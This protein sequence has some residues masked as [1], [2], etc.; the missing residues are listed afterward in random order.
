MSKEN[1]KEVVSEALKA[2]E[3]LRSMWYI[4]DTDGKLWE[5]DEF[6]FSGHD[7]LR[8]FSGYEYEKDRSVNAV[9][10]QLRA[11]GQKAGQ[12][13]EVCEYGV[14]PDDHGDRCQRVGQRVA[15]IGFAIDH[16]V[17][18]DADDGG[19]QEDVLGH[20]NDGLVLHEQ[21]EQAEYRQTQKINRPLPTDRTEDLFPERFMIGRLGMNAQVLLVIGK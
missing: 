5:F 4:L 9:L 13:I 12:M 19:N 1:E 16:R 20:Q 11:A 6:D 14:D 18:N 17:E 10:G 3:K 7:N 8:K 21:P 15:A 2:E